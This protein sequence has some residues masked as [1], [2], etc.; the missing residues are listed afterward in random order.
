MVGF[1]A[2]LL[3]VILL[4]VTALWV[5]MPVLASEPQQRLVDSTWLSGRLHKPGLVV[6]DTRSRALYDQGH[7][8]GAVS[9]PVAETFGPDPRSDLAAPISTI[10]RLFSAAGVDQET[11]VVL[12]DGGDMVGASRVFWIMEIHG[13]HHVAL[14]NAGFRDWQ[15]RGLPVS[16]E[17]LRPTPRTFVSHVNPARLA[18]KFST[19]LAIDDPDVQ[20]VDVRPGKA[21]RGETDGQVRKGH[22]PTAI[23]M[24]F[25]MNL[26]GPGEG[27]KSFADLRKLYQGIDRHKKVI[28]YCDKGLESTLAY[29][30]LRQLGYD[31]ATYDGSW[32]EWS[33]DPQLPIETG[34]NGGGGK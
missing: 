28:T 4:S 14:L 20:I 17:A 30:V 6:L 9:L 32:Y 3:T 5:A 8:A 15:A 33:N 10:Q 25:N 1:C 7:I 11:Q 2:R 21:Y 16:D 27:L 31:V 22:I 34:G 23:N 24:P 26:R 29:F 12:Y 13:Q 18:T 19:R